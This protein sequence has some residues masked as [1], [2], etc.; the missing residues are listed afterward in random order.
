L[1]ESLRFGSSSS[2]KESLTCGGSLEGYGMVVAEKEV[3]DIR[4]GALCERR[5]KMRRAKEYC[6]RN[7]NERR[8]SLRYF[9]FFLLINCG[10]FYLRLFAADSSAFLVYFCLICYE[11]QKYYYNFNVCLAYYFFV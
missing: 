5:V 2:N 11:N 1:K 4:K 3:P 7:S 10:G 6:S 8:K 9:R